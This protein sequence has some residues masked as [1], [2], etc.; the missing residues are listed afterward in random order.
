M[1]H[2][3]LEGIGKS[4]TV[5]TIEEHWGGIRR[6]LW[7]QLLRQEKNQSRIFYNGNHLLSP[8]GANIV[9][10]YKIFVYY[11]WDIHIQN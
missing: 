7:K 11:C 1:V 5:E 6:S 3:T 10:R 8:S 4:P 9:F 2:I